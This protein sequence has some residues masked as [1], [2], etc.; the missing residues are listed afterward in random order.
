MLKARSKVATGLL[1]GLLDHFMMLGG[2]AIERDWK[3]SIPNIQ[4][5]A[6]MIAVLLEGTAMGR[7]VLIVTPILGQQNVVSVLLDLDNVFV[8]RVFAAHDFED[9]Q[10]NARAWHLSHGREEKVSVKPPP[11]PTF[12]PC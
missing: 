10:A 4:E 8:R 1:K 3:L 7:D 6:C 11:Q 2:L 9:D 12:A 5:E